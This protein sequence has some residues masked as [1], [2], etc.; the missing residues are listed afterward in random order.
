MKPIRQRFRTELQALDNGVEECSETMRTAR[1]LKLDAWCGCHGKKRINVK[2]LHFFLEKVFCFWD[3]PRTAGVL[4]TAAR[5]KTSA[6]SQNP[7]QNPRK[8][9]DGWRTPKRFREPAP[10]PVAPIR[11]KSFA[12]TRREVKPSLV[13]N[14]DVPTIDVMPSDVPLTSNG[15]IASSPQSLQ[16]PTPLLRL[17]HPSQK[18]RVSPNCLSRSMMLT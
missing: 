1:K 16:R 15:V 12:A 11:R 14:V 10:P 13:L 9:M 8:N 6:P 4:D 3:V 18:W 17:H 7:R 2:R 5:K